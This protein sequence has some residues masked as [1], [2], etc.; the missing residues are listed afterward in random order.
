MFW[1]DFSFLH[2]VKFKIALGYALLFLLSFLAVFGIVLFHLAAANRYAA[3]TRLN[4]VSRKKSTGKSRN[5]RLVSCLCWH[6][7]KR[8]N[9]HITR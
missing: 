5:G 7:A 6:F 4:A 3:D 9:G 8:R 1:N 2:T